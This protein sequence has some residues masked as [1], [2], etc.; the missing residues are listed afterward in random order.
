MDE[1]RRRLPVDFRFGW[2][3][4]TEVLNDDAEALVQFGS[5]LDFCITVAWEYKE[6]MSKG[7]RKKKDCTVPWSNLGS[8]C[9]GLGYVCRY[10]GCSFFKRYRNEKRR[11]TD[12]KNMYES[13]GLG[14]R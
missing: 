9:S 3:L 8:W 11:E 4:A 2:M 13:G 14:D 1:A 7:P 12:D 6:R 10:E 5:D